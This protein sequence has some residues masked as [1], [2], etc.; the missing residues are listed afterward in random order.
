[1][2]KRPTR[3]VREAGRSRPAVASLPQATRRAVS[4]PGSRRSKAEE[5]V[6]PRASSMTPVPAR[7]CGGC[8]HESTE[9]ARCRASGRRNPSWRPGVYGRRPGA[10]M[11]WVTESAG[12]GGWV[13]GEASEVGLTSLTRQRVRDWCFGGGGDICRRGVGGSSRVPHIE[14]RWAL[15]SVRWGEQYPLHRSCQ[16]GRQ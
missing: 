12:C 10:S 2:K 5:A 14:S 9:P 16:R 6:P 7:P 8:E 4:A 11:S 3:L 15:A 13:P 1:M